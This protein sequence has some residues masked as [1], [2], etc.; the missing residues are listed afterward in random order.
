M[1]DI[2]PECILPMCERVEDQHIGTWKALMV[3]EDQIV[4]QVG[5]A[6][7]PHQ[8]ACLKIDIEGL[9]HRFVH[10]KKQMTWFVTAVGGPQQKKNDMPTVTVLDEIAEKLALQSSNKYIDD[11]PETAVA[12]M[13]EVQNEEPLYDPMCELNEIEDSPP[14]ET[15]KK[16]RQFKTNRLKPS[17]ARTVLMPRRPPYVQCD[18]GLT[19]TV[20]CWVKPKSK[21]LYIKL[22]DLDWLC[23]Y[24]ADQHHYQG[25]TRAT[26]VDP[27]TAVAATSIEWDFNR[28]TFDV[29]VMNQSYDIPLGFMSQDI[30]D[31]LVEACEVE[32]HSGVKG[33]ARYTSVVRRQ[34]FRKCLDM[35]CEATMA[36]KR[37]EFENEWD[38][39]IQSQAKRRK[40]DTHGVKSASAGDESQSAIAEEL[41]TADAADLGA[42]AADLQTAVAASSAS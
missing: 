19:K 3:L 5:F 38:C 23:S 41:M 39:Q 9:P 34:A 25:I 16:K 37:Q 35:W 24:A 31:K 4:L 22:E 7:A 2:N 18:A 26:C 15:P 30:Y 21:S 14:L 36:G 20:H 8:A 40:I 32:N 29:K 6:K 10:V 1:E 28:K 33:G 42:D 17:M 11:E 12:A 27:K 13:G